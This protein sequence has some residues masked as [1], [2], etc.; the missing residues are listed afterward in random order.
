ML[1]VL[2]ATPNLLAAGVALLGLL[3][4][5][6]IIRAEPTSPYPAVEARL[7]GCESVGW[8]SFWI[9]S[10]DPLGGSLHRVRPDG[11]SRMPA[12]DVISI[13]V[14]N[15]LNA[16]LA[17]MIHQHKR[18]VLHDLRELDEGMFAATVTVNDS[19]VVSD[20]ILLDLREKLGSTNR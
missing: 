6:A 19:N 10:L 5:P 9:E 16:L 2:R 1:F 11:V 7:R 12:N 17:S 13:A 18:I 3:S 8:C 14:R 15:R 20:P 4:A